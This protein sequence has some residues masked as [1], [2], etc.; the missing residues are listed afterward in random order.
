MEK[1]LSICIPSYNVDKYLNETLKSLCVKDVIDN[2]EVLI[3]DDGSKDT[4][5]EIAYSYC[6][7]YPRTFFYYYKENGGY[8]SVLNLGI[9]LAKGKYFKI[10]D[11]DDWFNIEK[12]A[13][14]VLAMK[15]NNADIVCNNYCKIYSFTGKIEYINYMNI[16]E[17]KIYNFR[18]VYKW[19]SFDLPQIAVKT[20][21]LKDN[22]VNNIDEKCLYV[23]NE[24][25][26]LSMA[27]VSTIVFIKDCIYFYRQQ[28][29]GQSI[30]FDSVIKNYKD[31]QKMVFSLMRFWKDIVLDKKIK[32]ENKKFIANLIQRKIGSQFIIYFKFPYS[33][34]IKE[35]LRDFDKNLQKSD[36]FKTLN[37]Y[38]MP[39]SFVLLERKFNYN[40]TLIF[41]I[42]IKLR[43][44][45]LMLRG[46]GR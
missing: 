21:I 2:I 27:H 36:G 5:S 1:I 31:H 20:S 13:N 14:L 45:F 6:K 25:I 9:Q 43:N 40:L 32:S 41:S 23:D 30:S 8:G 29:E 22:K 34:S 44:K 33:N 37:E 19:K 4:T 46:F 7:K 10:L 35:K 11:G 24:Y 39:K 42:F 15:K 28:R 3:I 18:D 12:L 38:S 16:M 17:N 26:V